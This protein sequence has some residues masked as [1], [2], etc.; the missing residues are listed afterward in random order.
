MTLPRLSLFEESEN[1]RGGAF[2]VRGPM[3]VGGP[4]DSAVSH[5]P[6]WE[7]GTDEGDP[8]YL[9]QTKKPANKPTFQVPF[10][11]F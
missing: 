9:P 1:A 2:W 7:R 10:H 3:E 4:A 6:E 8:A 11:R 5:V